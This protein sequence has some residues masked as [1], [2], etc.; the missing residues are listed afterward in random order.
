MWTELYLDL[1][2]L[3]ALTDHEPAM[4]GFIRVWTFIIVLQVMPSMHLFISKA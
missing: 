4:E 1:N 3:L 2:R